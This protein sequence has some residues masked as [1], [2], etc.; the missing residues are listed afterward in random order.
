MILFESRK[1]RCV[2][3][4]KS[5]R[6]FYEVAR[7]GSFTAAAEALSIA[8]PAMSMSIK[9]LEEQLGLSLFH[10][11]DRQISLTDEGLSLYKQAQPILQ[12]LENAQRVMEELRGL[13]AG[14]VRVGIPGM[15]GSYYFPPLLMAFRHQYPGIKLTIIDSGADRLQAM[16]EQGELDLAFIVSEAVPDS[17]EASSI[18]TLPMVAV[19]SKDHPFAQLPAVNIE[20]F[21][22]EELAIFKEGYFHRRI[23]DQMAEKS[24][25]SPNIGIETNL[26]HLMKSFVRNGFGVTSFLDIVLEDEEE[27]VGV[28]FLTPFRLSIHLAWRKQGYLSVANQCFR[29]FIIEHGVQ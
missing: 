16:L 3:E 25:I 24:G 26:I 7:L 14:Q 2:V 27:L 10:R 9:R 22:K 11:I 13:D 4:S 12:G 1:Q 5:L 21:L 23:I 17:L 28:P 29:D 19:V 20:A 8:Q 15:L 6:Y 18:M